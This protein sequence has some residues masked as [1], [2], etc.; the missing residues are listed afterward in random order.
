MRIP[1][2]G[3]HLRVLAALLL[4]VGAAQSSAQSEA[5]PPS[6][7][8]PISAEPGT[9]SSTAA[10]EPVEPAAPPV[11]LR[12]TAPESEVPS[13]E[14]PP[15]PIPTPEELRAEAECPRILR[16]SIDK[17]ERQITA[18]CA[19]GSVRSFRVALG[20]LP[21]GYKREQH[22]L[23]TPEGFYR[24]AEAP[25]GSR[26]HVFMLLDYPSLADADRA[27]STGYIT[28]KTYLRIARAVARG[29]LPPQDTLLGGVIGIHGE[30]DA[31]RGRSRSEDWTLGCIALSDAEAEWIAQRV[32]VGTPVSIEP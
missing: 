28:P 2:I 27:L 10:S 26:F 30:G 17:S 23:R 4:A 24:I 25:R 14:P 18:S 31:H 8:P 7:E 9:A 19:G 11:P 29:D 5:E 1:S 13:I 21:L 6:A 12:A 32:A 20:Q 22:D 16:L 3:S 15:P